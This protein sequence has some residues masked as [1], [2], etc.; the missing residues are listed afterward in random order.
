MQNYLDLLQDILDNGT[1]KG[2]RT[3]TGT[4]SVFGRQIRFDLRKGFPLV[5][6]KFVPLKPIAV[7][8]DWFI[9]GDT[10]IKYLVD[11][12]CK[13]WNEWALTQEHL[14]NIKQDYHLTNLERFEMYLNKIE[15]EQG[16]DA[17]FNEHIKFTKTNGG[18][19]V[20]EGNKILDAAGIPETVNYYNGHKVGDLG[21]VYGKQ[22]RSWNTTSGKT[23]DQLKEVIDLLKTKPNSRRIIVSAW[24][25]EDLPD[26]SISPQD[27]V[28][29][30]K[31][32]LAA[33]HTLFQFYTRDMTDLEKIQ[34]LFET[35]EETW[36]K[37]TP[38]SIETYSEKD[39]DSVNEYFK[40][41]NLPTKYL[42]CQLYQRS[43]DI[44]LGVPFNIASYALLTEL[45]AK[46]VNMVTHEFVHTF[47]DVH[48][49]NNH[50]E[51]IK[52]QLTRE[53]K[54]L[55]KLIFKPEFTDV[56]NFKFTDVELQDYEHHPAIRG[57]VS[58]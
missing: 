38:N 50:I 30:D 11:N 56:L 3:G 19:S 51:Q 9:K 47:G 16:V 26:E 2:D 5:T 13:I 44:F 36:N 31:M 32:A 4:I 54:P 52:L 25:P 41:N 22:W 33:C 45:I 18:L 20:E 17:K 29:N 27:N 48:I 35:D 39:I 42:S 6:S 28:L 21:P 49:Y 53:P 10:N 34:Y 23:I 7:E 1:Q 15:I 43:A 40:Q 14:E 58:V 8:L 55:P 46:S 37:L 57:K 12:G 24:N